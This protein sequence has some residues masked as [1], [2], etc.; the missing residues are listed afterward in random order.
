VDLKL[1]TKERKGKSGTEETVLIIVTITTISASGDSVAL[2]SSP[3]GSQ[4]TAVS[5]GICLLHL[6]RAGTGFNLLSPGA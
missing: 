6:L 2:S 1:G 4:S 3:L 5:S